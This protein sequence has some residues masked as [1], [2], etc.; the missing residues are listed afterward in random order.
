LQ[1]FYQAS[2]DFRLLS[3]LPD[4]VIGHSAGRIYPFVEGMN[5]VLG[6]VRDE[7]T[8]DEI[9]KRIAE[10]RPRAKTDVAKRAL[11][12][13]EV[14]VERRAAE[15]VNQPGPHREKARAALV[16]AS[17]GEWSPG[18]PRLM[19]D[20]LARLGKITQQ[21]LAEEQLRQLKGL[22]ESAAAGSIDRLHIAHR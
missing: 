7:A 16:R 15:V 19:A 4:A 13:L 6:E 5:D 22:H 12:L 2:H 18:E 3:G 21:A 11:D 17:K 1:R 14:L 9:V 10:V 20:F 8:A